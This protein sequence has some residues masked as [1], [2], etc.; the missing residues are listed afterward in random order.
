MCTVRG[1]DQA[2]RMPIYVKK[3]VDRAL[4]GLFQSE[5]ES[6]GEVALCAGL[7]MV[8]QQRD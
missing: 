1:G 3:C 8:Y 5:R 2:T 7:L 6:R 4:N